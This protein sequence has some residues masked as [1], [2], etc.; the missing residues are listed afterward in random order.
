[1]V[2]D[3][4]GFFSKRINGS[5]TFLAEILHDAAIKVCIGVSAF[6]QHAFNFHDFIVYRIICVDD[7]IS[8]V[9]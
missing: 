9:K 3:I 2:V 8:P 5:F 6:Y 1:M 7:F 4:G